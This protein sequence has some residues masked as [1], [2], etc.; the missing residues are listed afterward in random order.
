MNLIAHGRIP[1][2]GN[3]EL[4]PL[5]GAAADKDGIVLLIEHAA[6]ALHRRVVPHFGAHIDDALCLFVEHLLGE[7]ERR[8]VHAHEATGLRVLLVDHDLVAKWQQ[9]VGDRERRWA[10]ADECDALAVA[11]GDG[12]RE[13]GADVIAQIGGD[14]LEAADGD[15]L[16]VDAAT[17][18]GGLAGAI[19][20]STQDAGKDIGLAVEQIRF[21]IPSL[22]N[23]P[24]VFR[25]VRVRGAGPLA[26]HHLVV[27]VGRADI[28][29][30][31]HS[32]SSRGKAMPRSRWFS[33]RRTKI[34]ASW[35]SMRPSRPVRHSCT[36]RSSRGSTAPFT[37]RA[38][39]P[40]TSRSARSPWPRR[41]SDDRS[42]CGAVA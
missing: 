25:D 5:G 6:Q 12:L 26:V 17:P 20:G 36:K 18:T 16:T 23:E 14:T 39:P 8:D 7:P 15:G 30:Q 9:V 2:P 37:R 33:I 3:V 42:R 31:S 11:V 38:A 21:R 1:A 19:A 32:A 41:Q 35:E 10:G 29:V 13:I 24:E 27:V 22:R 4:L 34:K 28:R 40:A